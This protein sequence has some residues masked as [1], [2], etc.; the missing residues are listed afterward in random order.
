MLDKLFEKRA[1]S[2]QSVFA[3]GDSFQIGS[4]SGTIVNNDTAFQVNAIYSAVSLISQTIS[5][6]PVDSYFRFDGARR[7]FRPA[8]EWVQN[9]DI[10]T[11][12]EAFYGSVIVSLL[13]DGN[14][15]IRIFRSEGRIVNLNV[16]NPTT[17][18]IKRNGIGRVMFEVQGEDR[19]LS[20]ED[21]LHIPDVVKPGS[22]RGVSR[23]EALK[24]NF[25]LAIALQNYSAKF[26]GQGTNTSGVLEVPGTLNA[27]QAA[28]LQEAFDSRHRGWK[29]S[30]KTAVLSGGASYKPTSINPQ[31]SQL[32]EA[33]NHAV[34][35]VA[36]AFSIPPHLLGLD[37]GMSYASVE[38]NNLAWVTHGLR[39]IVSKLES[40]F[41]KLIRMSPGAENAFIKWNLDGL[42][43]ADYNSRLAGYSTGLQSGFFSINDIRRFEDLAPVD[44]PSAETVRVPLQNVNVE[45]ATISSQSQKVKMATALVSVGYDPKSVL[46]SL[47]LPD[48]EHSGLPSVQLQG[49][50]N[51]DPEDPESVYDVED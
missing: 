19:P 16:L 49:V 47:G 42:L 11:T 36:R 41:S 13:L 1:L 34:A 24:E 33:R 15:F 18:K 10:D 30:H 7:P 44:D 29:N 43:R 20:T 6:L 51:I 21:I 25:G 27:D 5:S 50:Q 40:G 46:E 4:N 28:Q 26:F 14:A 48:I 31:D 9:P 22:I 2:F 17:V 35:D 32:L 8:P 23:T 37:Q 3:S 38:Q 39:P 12:K 45:N